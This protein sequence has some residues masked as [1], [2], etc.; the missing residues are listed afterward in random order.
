[1]DRLDLLKKLSF[2][3]QVAEDEVASLQ[4]YFVRT[5]QWNRIANGDIDIIRGEKGAG[6]S[7]LYLLLNKNKDQLF[8]RNVL[9]VSAENPRGTTVFKDLISDPPASEREF[10]VLWKLYILVIICHEMRE[11]GIGDSAIRSVYG[12]L[13]EAELLERELNLSGVLRMAQSFAR[14][15]LSGAKY[16]AGL[17]LDPVTG[18]PS[19][20]IGRISLAEPVGELRTRGIM[21]LDGLFQKVNNSLKEAGRS[22]WVLLD[23]LDVAFAESHELEANAIRALVRVYTDLGAL[24]NISMKIFLREDIWKRVTEEGFR[25]ASHIV[26]FEIMNWTN[27]M[28]LNLAMRRILNNDVLCQ[29]LGV[30]KEDVLSDS[31]KQDELF[32]RIFPPQV[33][34]GIQKATTFNWMIGRC[35]D[36][37]G[38]TAPREFIHLLNCIKDEEIRRLER[39]GAVPPEEQLFDR[40]VFKLALP[41][42]SS[43]RLDT[44]LYAEYK[45][46]RPFIEKLEGEKTEQTPE[47]LSVI[48]GVDRDEALKKANGLVALG[49][50]ERRGTRSEPTFWVPFLYRDGLNLRQGKADI[51]DDSVEQVARMEAANDTDGQ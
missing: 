47:S 30:D 10:I 3:T 29:E 21:S 40:S 1:M 27:P 43:T 12:A 36:G 14:R 17:E 4:E 50:F 11:F 51:D 33:E 35:A 39:G 42:V 34:Q 31:A 7:A 41:T 18:T 20:I 49:F 38:K 22:V 25:E 46:E 5:D 24:D 48:W 2:G 19:G 26:R 8:D 6:K 45:A 23:R 37:T 28:L 9:L 16:E 32:A 44:Y 15:L 13:E